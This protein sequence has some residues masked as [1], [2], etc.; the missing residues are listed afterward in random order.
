MTILVTGG[1]SGLGEA[2]TRTLAAAGHTVCFTYASSQ[3]RA[4]ELQAARPGS[5]AIHCDFT[6]AASVEALLTA[7]PTLNIDVLVNNANGRI[8]KDHF[9]KMDADVFRSSFEHNVLP[10]LRIT[11]E[12]IKVFRKKK[13]GKIVN[14]ISAAIINKPPFGYSEYIAN[15][16]YLLSM[17]KSWAN[18]Y[19]RFNI[20][21]NSISPGFMLTNITS[22][23]DERI[24]EQ[25]KDAHP[26]KQLLQPME[27]ANAVK[28]YVEASQQ[29]N[30]TNLVINAGA[31]IA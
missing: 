21:S 25:I 23:T 12:A 26:L 30:G 3:A 8:H 16:A 24:V 22:D 15:K 5:R 18:E 4:M 20:T 14:I 7:I 31:D 6:S 1:A 11:Q 9:Y 29:I 13:F 28:F 10:T 2:I 27:V 19:I 17:S